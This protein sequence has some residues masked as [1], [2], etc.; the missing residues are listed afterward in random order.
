MHQHHHHHQQQQQ[1][2]IYAQQQQANL[3]LYQYN[4]LHSMQATYSNPTLSP[5]RYPQQSIEQQQPYRTDQLVP[6]SPSSVQQQHMQ[7]SSPVNMLPTSSPDAWL[8]G[9][10]LNNPEVF[11]P[12]I[13]TISNTIMDVVPY[14]STNNSVGSTT[15][16]PPVSKSFES[17]KLSR[18]HYSKRQ[19]ALEN[20]QRRQRLH[21]G[22]SCYE[23]DSPEFS[24]TDEDAFQ[25]R[26][27]TYNLFIAPFT[28]KRKANPNTNFD[29]IFCLLFIF[30]FRIDF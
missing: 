15:S 13:R 24:S 27:K 9:T 8:K 11:R 20:Y 26:K 10:T 12:I 17:P 5:V 18:H 25:V 22:S 21:S 2:A 30:F 3:L 19:S 29:N 4:Q 1:Q 16:S 6:I 14:N 23:S 28:N 7:K